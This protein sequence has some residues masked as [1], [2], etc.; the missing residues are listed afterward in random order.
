MDGG[1]WQATIHGVTES[2]TR[3]SDQAGALGIHG[4]EIDCPFLSFWDAPHQ[5]SLFNH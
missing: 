2:Q 4:H 1:A 5:R 3:R